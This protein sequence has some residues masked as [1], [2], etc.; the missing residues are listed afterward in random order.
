M[1][2]ICCGDRRDAELLL[3]AG[4]EGLSIDEINPVWLKTPVAPFAAARI[5]QMPID[6]EHI[7]AALRALQDRFERVVV[8]GVGG[9]ARADS[10]RLFCERFGR[11]DE[12]A[13]TGGCAES[14]RVP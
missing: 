10:S 4:S 14:A 3:A 1:K 12:V 9:W 7:I 2:P 8:E 5:E 6:I 11:R 13:G